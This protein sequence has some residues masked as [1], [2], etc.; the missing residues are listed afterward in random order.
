MA[1]FYRVDKR[2][3]AV[4]D[5]IVTAEEYYAKFTGAAKVVEDSREATRPSSVPPRRSCLFVFSDEVAARKHWSKMTGGKL[6]AVA[7]DENAMHHTG[8]MALMDQMKAAAE[9][10][11]EVEELARAYWAGEESQAP[12]FEILVDRATVTAVISSS[13]QERVEHLKRRLGII[14]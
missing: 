4:G 11:E 10:G 14:K 13:D 12:E 9:Q 8:D 7:I 3:F 6:Y 5:E 2:V 1:I